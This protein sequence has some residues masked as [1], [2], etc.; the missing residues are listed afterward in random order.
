MV[1]GDFFELDVACG[2][3]GDRH[4]HV[5]QITSAPVAGFAAFSERPGP[6]TERKVEYTCPLTGEVRLASF[7]PP[8]GFRWPFAITKIQ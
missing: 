8:E 4:H 1:A 6:P 3:G 2:E 5:L 7:K